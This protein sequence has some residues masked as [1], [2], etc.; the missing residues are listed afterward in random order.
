LIRSG[1]YSSRLGQDVE[2][3]RDQSERS[4]SVIFD[5]KP[6]E[7]MTTRLWPLGR[8]SVARGKML[9]N[10]LRSGIGLDAHHSVSLLRTQSWPD[11]V[12]AMERL[13]CQFSENQL[14]LGYA[15]DWDWIYAGEAQKKTVQEGNHEPTG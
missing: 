4:A 5:R 14:T 15:P 1:F 12:D 13:K 7:S 9:W 11:F 10:Y 3:L 8:V 2:I 6:S